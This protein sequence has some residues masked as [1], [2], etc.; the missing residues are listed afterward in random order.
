MVLMLDHANDIFL[1]CDAG[2]GTVV[3]LPGSTYLV[4]SDHPRTPSVMKYE[5]S[6]P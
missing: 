6:V 5:V 4:I 3:G 1:I 2:G